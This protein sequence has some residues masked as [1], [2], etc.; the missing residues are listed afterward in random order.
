[1]TAGGI[2]AV[3]VT[4]K[5]LTTQWIMNVWVQWNTKFNLL[6]QWWFWNTEGKCFSLLSATLGS[7]M[8]YVFKSNAK[9]FSLFPS[10]SPSLFLPLVYNCHVPSSCWGHKN[11][12]PAYPPNSDGVIYPLWRTL[13]TSALIYPPK[14]C[15]LTLIH[16]SLFSGKVYMFCKY[17]FVFLC[18]ESLYISC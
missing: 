8:L 13:P 17:V 11:K 4:W 3:H 18:P 5:C 9:I 15:C 16:N 10:L 2:P 7:K 12:Y 6:V 14:H 1:M